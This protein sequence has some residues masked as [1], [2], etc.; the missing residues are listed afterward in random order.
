MTQAPSPSTPP[1]PFEALLLAAGLGTRLRPLTDNRPKALVEVNGETLLD[2]NIRRLAAAGATHIVVNVHHLADMIEDHLGRNTYPVALSLSDE[3]A[4][5]L[6]TGGAVAR[7]D[8][9]FS[10]QLPVVIHNVDVLSA[11]DL[12]GLVAQHSEQHN[13]ATLAVS[14]RNTHRQ[15][16]ARPDGRL[17]GWENKQSG[18]QI[19]ATSDVDSSHLTRWAFS[20]IAVVDPSLP[21]LLPPATRPYPI[22][23]QYLRL[24]STHRIVCV[25][26]SATDWLDVGKPET[27][28]LASDFL[29]SHAHSHTH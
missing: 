4:L 25:P 2:I 17:A 19:V 29:A 16:M 1:R 10:G 18:E 26:H 24:A 14:S 13:L 8:A 3:R 22:V 15:L 7:A 9:L 6:D 23:P 12:A 11:L 20:G 21:K 28:A 5:L 27:L